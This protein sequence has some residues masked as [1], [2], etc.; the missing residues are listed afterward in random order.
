MPL[1]LLT[2]FTNIA[3][4]KYNFAD[5]SMWVSSVYENVIANATVLDIWNDGVS[6]FAWL[7]SYVAV[8]LLIGSLIVT[9]FGKRLAEPVKFVA[10]FVIAFCLGTCYISPLLDPFIVIEHWIM[11]LI[12][13]AVAG[14]MYKFVYSVIV[15]VGIGYP[16]YMVV[17][18]PDVLTEL[19]SGNAI[20]ALAIAAV[21]LAII[22]LLRRYTELIGFAVFGAWL[23]ANS[24]RGFF[25][26]TA[27]VDGT[28]WI[29]ILILTILI[30]IP[31]IVVQFKTRKIF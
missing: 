19:F 24:I 16:V 18:R 28:G 31:G 14:V 22:F 10:I 6:S 9:F 21:A 17:Y 1:D 13:A 25:D 8:V 5:I 20:V 3:E 12:V 11:G 30:S 2:F 7:S 15:I 4:A 29:I 26:Y 23:T 27:L